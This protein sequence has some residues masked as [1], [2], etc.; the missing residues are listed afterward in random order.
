M[1][2]KTIKISPVND[3]FSIYI[4]EASDDIYEEGPRTPSA[5]GIYHFD[6][7]KFSDNDA[8]HDLIDCMVKRHEEEIEG[9][10][11]SKE[12]LEKLN[13]KGKFKNDG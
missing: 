11:K 13:Q 1:R 8:V 3:K 5:M 6:C 10:K 4:S 9:L 7:D 12:A 2:I